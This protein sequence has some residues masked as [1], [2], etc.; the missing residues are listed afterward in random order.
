MHEGT[1]TAAVSLSCRGAHEAPRRFRQ[2][3]SS[4]ERPNVA[5][6]GVVLGVPTA[7]IAL[8]G[9]LLAGVTVSV[10]V[11]I[12]VGLQTAVFCGMIGLGLLRNFR[13]SMEERATSNT[14][15]LR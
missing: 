1:K 10:A 3:P 12:A 5:L 8:V 15:A 14:G 11:L 13:A 9:L 2:R 6:A 4:V 7:V